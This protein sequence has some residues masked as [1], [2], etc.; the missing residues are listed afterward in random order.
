MANVNRPNGASPVR[1]GDANPFTSQATLYW[2]P[3]GDTSQYNIGD[4]V[5]SAE[6]VDTVYG[7]PKITKSATSTSGAQRGVIVGFYVDPNNLTVNNVPATKTHD[8]YAMVIDDPAVVFEMTDDGITTASLTTATVGQNCG[9]TVA[10]PTSPAP[11]SATV[12]TSS[13]IATTATL[14][15]KIVGIRQIP[16]NAPGAYCRWLVRINQHELAG[17]T[18]GV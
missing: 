10:N 16:G 11:V 6:G 9:F 15:L 13:T 14:P 8:Y 1:S 12:I 7:A 2:I 4:F 17:N 18:A 3:S 5:K